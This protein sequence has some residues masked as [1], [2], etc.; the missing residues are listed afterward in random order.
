MVFHS[1]GKKYTPVMS[2]SIPEE[3]NDYQTL[4]P[5]PKFDLTIH[6]LVTASTISILNGAVVVL[7]AIVMII[8]FTTTDTTTISSSVQSSKLAVP[9]GVRSTQIRS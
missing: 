4:T 3:E 6:N 9:Q 5:L 8:L 7:M 2:Q 1:I